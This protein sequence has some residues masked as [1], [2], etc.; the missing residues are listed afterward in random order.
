MEAF[1]ELVDKSEASAFAT[2][3]MCALTTLASAPSQA[4]VALA[5]IMSLCFS[6]W[7]VGVMQFASS[8]N[9]ASPERGA[10]FDSFLTHTIALVPLYAALLAYKN[11]RMNMSVMLGALL[12]S[13][14]VGVYAISEEEQSV[15][16]ALIAAARPL[17]VAIVAGALIAVAQQT[18]VAVA[19][20]AVVEMAYV[21][22]ASYKPGRSVIQTIKTVTGVTFPASTPEA[23]PGACEPLCVE[24]GGGDA[25]SACYKH[26]ET[27]ARVHERARANGAQGLPETLGMSTL[28][29]KC[30]RSHAAGSTCVY[31][32]DGGCVTRSK[33]NTVCTRSQAEVDAQLARVK[34]ASQRAVV[35]GAGVLTLDEQFA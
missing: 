34:A 33:P 21:A 35:S 11:A 1:T 23:P 8:V 4:K 28:E 7:I 20:V 15:Q 30:L 25:E 3:A 9:A 14:G 12:V 18:A 22:I 19:S 32:Q 27:V 16:D 13:L 26:N 17:S 29:R 2:I 10:M 6:I 24:P 31:C 5:V